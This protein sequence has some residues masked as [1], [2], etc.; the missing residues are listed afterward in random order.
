MEFH[1]FRRLQAGGGP[2]ETGDRRLTTHDSRLTWAPIASEIM[3]KKR[4]RSAGWSGHDQFK[5]DSGSA[6]LQASSSVS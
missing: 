5:V 2:A 4:A 6:F 1:G 3:S